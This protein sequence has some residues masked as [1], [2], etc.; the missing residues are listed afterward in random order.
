[1]TK[2]GGVTRTTI[3]L[4]TGHERNLFNQGICVITSCLGNGLTQGCVHQAAERQ[5]MQGRRGSRRLSRRLRAG[6]CVC[7]TQRVHPVGEGAGEHAVFKSS[8]SLRGDG[9]KV[10]NTLWCRRTSRSRYMHRSKYTTDAS[11]L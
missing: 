8:F 3:E 9:H 7:A 1:M 11:Q 4:E 2:P 10:I 6:I 5:V